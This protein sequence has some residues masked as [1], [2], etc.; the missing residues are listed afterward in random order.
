M[1]RKPKTYLSRRLAAF[2]IDFSIIYGTA[3]ILYNVLQLFHLYLTIVRL[4]LIIALV[5]YPVITGIFKTSIGKMLFGL[6]IENNRKTNYIKSILFREV[7]YKQLFLILPISLVLVLNKLE[8]LSPFFE[9]LCTFLI[10]SILFVIFLFTKKTWYDQLAKT[11]VVIDINYKRKLV[12]KGI[13]V[14]AG[15]CLVVFGIRTYFYLTTESFNIPLIPKHSSRVLNPYVFFL[16]TQKNA[17]DYIFELFEKNDIV[18]LCEGTHPEMTQYDFIFDL[19][20]DERFI[21]QVGNVFSEIG[22]STQQSNLDS[23]MNTNQL[24]QDTLETKLTNILRNYSHYPIWENTNYYNYFKKLYALNQKLPT[25][26][27]IKHF[28]TDLKCNWDSIQSQKDYRSIVKSKFLTRDKIMADNVISSYESMIKSGVKR[29]KCLVIMNNRHA[30][31]PAANSNIGDVGQSCAAYIIKKYPD[32]TANVLLNTLKTSFGLSLPNEPPYIA[33]I[34]FMA[35][36]NGIWD[37]SFFK[38]GNKSWGFNFKNSPFG[39]DAFDLHFMPSLKKLNY[40]DIFT[41]FVFFKPIDEHYFSV[42]FKNIISDSFDNEIINRAI[43]IQD[44]AM[45]NNLNWWTR[46]VNILRKQEVTINPKPYQ[47]LES[48]FELIFGTILLL[49]GLLLGFSGFMKRRKI[50]KA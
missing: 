11:S 24:N 20:S 14:L 44:D 15:V 1:R 37:N 9:I 6:T 42:G 19:V 47:Q 23:L 16:K 43:R 5:Y 28:F 34:Q 45:D 36:K 3:F 22:S 48:V 38:S 2:I 7:V 35:I 41:G 13:F 27:R 4:T 17:K 31:G 39:K 33:P 32:K 50:T 12:K 46:K 30:F 26:K 8:W 29:H 10:S 49:L 40:Q 21:E 25:K 18:I